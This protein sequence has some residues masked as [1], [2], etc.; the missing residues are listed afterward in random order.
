MHAPGPKDGI[1][2]VR[3]NS[4]L[5]DRYTK[6]RLHTKCKIFKAWIISESHDIEGGLKEVMRKGTALAKRVHYVGANSEPVQQI[7]GIPHQYMRKE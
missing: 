3:N 2:R 6:S 7:V 5:A 4:A 1:V